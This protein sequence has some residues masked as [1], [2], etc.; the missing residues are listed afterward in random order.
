LSLKKESLIGAISHPLRKTII[1]ILADAPRTVSEVVALTGRTQPMVSSNLAILMSANVVESYPLGRERIYRL[2]P[3]GFEDLVD[4]LD[5][6]M[7]ARDENRCPPFNRKNQ[8]VTELHHART[9]YDHLAGVEGVRMLD[10][11]LTRKWLLRKGDGS[12]SLALT[13]EGETGLANLEIEMPLRKNSKRIF[14]YSCMDWTVK[15]FHLG[16]ALGF[17]LL[18]GLE[19]LGYLERVDG[20]RKVIVNRELKDFFKGHLP[21]TFKKTEK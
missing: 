2:I 1:E 20:S 11:L 21:A 6:I 19:N 14:A 17:S 13:A 18:K 15:R 4:W 12:K 7:H 8:F 5:G 16:G 3:E 9:C 10:E